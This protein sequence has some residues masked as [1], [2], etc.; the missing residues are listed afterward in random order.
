MYRS[1]QLKIRRGIA[2]FCGLGLAVFLIGG[3]LEEPQQSLSEEESPYEEASNADLIA[4]WKAMLADVESLDGNPEPIRL[5]MELSTRSDTALNPILDYMAAPETQPVEKL[6]TVQALSTYVSPAYIDELVALQSD[7]HDPLTRACATALLGEIND[8]QVIPHL[9][10]ALEDPAP[11]VQFAAK[12][13]LAQHGDDAIREE[14]RQEYFQPDTSVEERAEIVRMLLIGPQPDDLD[15]LGQALL[16]PDT[17]NRAR[18]NIVLAMSRFGDIPAIQTLRQ[19]VAVVNEDW[20]TEM[21]NAAV[22]NIQD[23]I[24]SGAAGV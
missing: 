24:N 4:Q 12:S 5:A 8:D 20:Y 3:C 18:A 16:E 2:L 13:G 19:S 17:A 11:R 7:E 6:A 1:R 23:R 10:A 15:V 9:R 22:K 14:L 21:V